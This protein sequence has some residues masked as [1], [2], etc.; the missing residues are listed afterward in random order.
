MALNAVSRRFEYQADRFA[1]ELHA[2]IDGDAA[3]VIRKK[4]A[5]KDMGTRPCWA[6]TRRF[7]LHAENLST[8]PGSTGYTLP[9]I[10]ATQH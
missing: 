1:C 3:S 10:T 9:I 5:M 2:I 8:S 4:E 6:R 7:R